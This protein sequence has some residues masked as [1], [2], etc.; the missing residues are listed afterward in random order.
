MR[1]IHFD[2]NGPVYHHYYFWQ[3]WGCLGCFG[4]ALLFIV[5]FTGFIFLL[6]QFRSCSNRSAAN[7]GQ[8]TTEVVQ[9]VVPPVYDDDDVIDDRGRRIVSNRLNVLFKAQVGETQINEWKSRFAQL[10][11]GD[12][13]KIVFTDINTK[14]MALEVPA[15]ERRDI[16]QNLPLQIS[17][18][19]FIVFEEEVMAGGYRP[20]DPALSGAAWHLDAVK[21][22]D[23]WDYTKGS[24]DIIVA[25][26]DSYFDLSNPEFA[27]TSIVGAYSVPRG[28]SDV[29]L[30]ADFNP[31]QP[32]A[33]MSHGTM[34][35]ALA[36]GGM[37][38]NHGSA[39]IAPRC[40]FMPVSLSSRIGTLN[41][42]QGLL[43][44]I[45][46]GAQ[47]INISAGIMFSDEMAQMPVEQ[48][49]QWAR[50]ELLSQEAVWKYVFEMCNDYRVTI[51]WAAGNENV[52]TALDAS[53]RGDSAIKVSAI[54]KNLNK[55][56]FSNFGNFAD[57]NI[58]E[59]TVSAPGVAVYGE[60]PS[61]GQG[62]A[63]DGTSFSAPIVAG[64]VGLMKSLDPSLTTSEIIEILKSTGRPVSDTTIGPIVQFG[65]A[66]ERVV[67]GFLPFSDLVNIVNGNERP[68]EKIYP[69]SL[70]RPLNISE[71]DDDNALPPLIQLSFRF[72]G[73]DNAKV[74]Y[75]SLLDPAHPWVADATV[76]YNA[77]SQTVNIIAGEASDSSGNSS[78]G[79]AGFTVKADE[80]GKAKITLIESSSISANYTPYIKNPVTTAVQ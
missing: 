28:D 64:G 75:T 44:A 7:S 35:A 15:D 36:I 10:Y 79:E 13:Y 59:S 9:P 16:M 55:A 3:P 80:R 38:N 72:A 74:Y 76:S 58:Y 30:P 51:I 17:D 42:L 52:F 45:N 66:L 68:F 71:E 27:N 11:P 4:R 29:S 31:A 21:A 63:V 33:A 2:S 40:S 14:L 57:K 53:K 20:N 25:V 70:V 50:T 67:Q 5:L 22:F 77:D 78:F 48:Q 37:D 34:V 18:I 19:P 23:A 73:G 46:H 61:S 1:R 43:Y 41:L 56:E 60:I 49:I 26:V 39:G 69:T 6:S 32:D 54:D 8:D 24:D 12:E 47:V 65:P 62:S